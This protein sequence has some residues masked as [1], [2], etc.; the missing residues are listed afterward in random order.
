MTR[1]MWEGK[2]GRIRF[3]HTASVS[4]P[5]SK[6]VSR[7]NEVVFK[8]A[9]W[10]KSSRSAT[11]LMQYIADGSEHV[12]EPEKLRDQD[13][14]EWSHEAAQE[15]VK[16]WHLAEDKDNLSRM[17]R[18]ASPADLRDIP[19]NERLQNRQCGHFIISFPKHLNMHEADLEQIAE[20]S[21]KPFA[22]QGFK[23]VY[24]PHTKAANPHVHVVMSTRNDSGE[25]LSLDRK[26]IQTIRE[27]IAHYG[28]SQGFKLEATPKEQHRGR[29]Y[30]WEKSPGGK[31]W[32]EKNFAY[33]SD[34]ERREKR[35]TLLERQ[36]PNWYNRHGLEFEA[37]RAGQE[38]PSH[39]PRT[40]EVSRPQLSPKTEAHLD[41]HFG[42]THQK[43]NLA[44][45]RFLEMASE[46]RRLAFWYVNNRP[47][48]FGA[49]R[50]NNPFKK[51]LTQRNVPLSNGWCRGTFEKMRE[52]VVTETAGTRNYRAG[53]LDSLRRSRGDIQPKQVNTPQ[54]Q[55]SSRP[56][57]PA[58][59]PGK[60]REPE[61]SRK[62]PLSKAA[63][64]QR[65]KALRRGAQKQ[66]R[67]PKLP[68]L[69]MER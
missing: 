10:G 22:D 36:V 40:A 37:V 58:T 54:P 6:S 24:V 38:L 19:E 25:A 23:Y 62:E 45:E 11:Q 61:V 39:V 69:D 51:E 34:D 42:A 16:D 52:A 28:R 64:Q 46:N 30:D 29:F 8:I 48:V 49:P 9:S 14:H 35:A 7:S 2:R 13:G 3:I 60:N 12:L 55:T 4:P 44:K 50:D 20:D 27:R 59:H 68:G 5:K 21:L 47:E 1:N 15:I 56:S 33:M 65:V 32:A 66:T 67:G 63:L 57:N 18:D 26:D 17:A 43:P 31:K 41:Q 53:A